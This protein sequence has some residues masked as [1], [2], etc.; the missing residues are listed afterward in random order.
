MD[1]TG[2]DLEALAARI[3]EK[4]VALDLNQTQLAARA[5][6]TQAALSQILAKQRKPG[7]EVLLKLADTLSVSIDYLVG[8]T[9]EPQIQDAIRH[10]RAQKLLTDFVQ[11]SAKDQQ[12]VLDLVQALKPIK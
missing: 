2:I 5:G 7:G 6:M 11:L 3:S 9:P 12:R 4:M 1:N 10:K 8:R